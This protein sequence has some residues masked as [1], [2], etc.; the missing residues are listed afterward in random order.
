M[1]IF[2]FMWTPSLPSTYNPGIVFSCYMVAIMIG[3]CL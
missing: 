1:Y 3:S 2:V